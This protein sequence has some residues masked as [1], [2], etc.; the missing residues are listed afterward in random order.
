LPIGYVP[1][2]RFKLLNFDWIEYL[3]INCKDR[4]NS[5]YGI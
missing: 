4:Y 2:L 5:T 1:K 3:Y